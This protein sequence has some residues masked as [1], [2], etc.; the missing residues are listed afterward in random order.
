LFF[1]FLTIV[2]RELVKNIIKFLD[3]NITNE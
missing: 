1:E 3:S 2:V